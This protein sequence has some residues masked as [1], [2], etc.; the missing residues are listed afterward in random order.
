VLVA[1]VGAL[2]ILGRGTTRLVLAAACGLALLGVWSALSVAW[3]GVPNEA[4]SALDRSLIAGAALLAGSILATT[5]HRAAVIAGAVLAG[6][7]VHA[8]EIMI[9]VAANGGGEDWFADRWLEGPVGYKNAQ[10]AIMVLGVVLAVWATS[11]SRVAARAA[12]GGAAGL[13]LGTLLLT[14]SRGALLAL[15]IAVV[16][17]LAWA[18]DLRLVVT[19]FP[20][21][22]AGALLG[23]ALRRVDAALVDGSRAEQLDAFRT[24]SLWT[25][26]AAVALAAVA[27]P[28]I[29]SRSARV[30]L[31]AGLTTLSLVLL[32]GVAVAKSSSF[33]RAAEIVS[34][35]G[36]DAQTSE[37]GGATRLTSL[38]LTGR[39]DAWRVARGMIA[40]DPIAGAGQG[41]FAAEW[42][43]ERRIEG[44]YVLQPHS[45][46]LELLS[47]L[48]V[49]GL[50]L[51]A[52][53]IVTAG[54]A[55]A[56]SPQRR[57][58]AVA[59]AARARRPGVGGLDVDV[60]GHRGARAPRRRRRRRGPPAGRVAG[61]P[62]G[63]RGRC[64][65]AARLVRR[66]V[67]ERAGPGRRRGSPGE[68]S[69]A[70]VREGSVGG[71]PQSLEPCSARAPRVYRRGGRKLRA[72][73]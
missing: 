54:L 73:S 6:V 27:A 51:F 24:Y 45:L 63:R 25:L 71:A 14:Q 46:E 4:W 60:R 58:A 23:L 19:A 56:R 67:P 72:R 38:S 33:P 22:G 70:R 32:A 10:A 15:G 64:R 69:G 7:T 57:L 29:S 55:A 53:A 26:V 17:Q 59:L 11:S 66:S 20:V 18:R 3:G 41:T 35:L 39:R 2:A 40:S 44:L 49:V 48:G 34:E 65:G 21:V 30:G 31:V 42:A 61:R 9:R 28:A 43:A 37:A 47:E 8:A 16:V 68:R 13:C 52:G 50:V 1:A 12:G 36:S 62:S 5:P